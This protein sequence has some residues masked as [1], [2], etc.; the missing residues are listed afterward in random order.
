MSSS[1][2]ALF[3]TLVF[4]VLAT[5]CSQV[6]DP[7]AGNGDSAVRIYIT[8]APSDYI[9]AAEVTISSVRLVPDDDDTGF[10]E[11][12]AA[13]ETPMTFDLIELQDGVNALLAERVVPAGTYSQLRLI[14][15]D[16]T[17]T[18]IDG[19][20]FNDGTVTQTLFVPSGAETG[21]KVKTNGVIEAEEDMVT[22]MVI[23]FDVD[24]SFVI[25]GDP[26]TPAGING[27]LFTPELVEVSR[28]E[29]SL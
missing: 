14:V 11:L 28:T 29:Q 12:L 17:V 3:A 8:D 24:H 13:D 15:A 4:L 27:I 5:A 21:I 2:L 6:D 26:E 25:N 9:A 7:V 1:R 18:L 19:Y 20:A 22:V 23:D 16:A 10:V